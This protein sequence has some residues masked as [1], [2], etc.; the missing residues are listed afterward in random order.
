MALFRMLNL[1]TGVHLK[2]QSGGAGGGVGGVCG[3]SS[4]LPYAGLVTADSLACSN[5]S[6]G[7]VHQRSGSG[8]TREACL[9]ASST[10]PAN[11]PL[12]HSKHSDEECKHIVTQSNTHTQKTPTPTQTL[13]LTVL[14]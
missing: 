14:P 4:P 5:R 12:M 7:G 6:T 10:T 13:T 9:A 8:Y 11:A 3:G 2:L 1:N